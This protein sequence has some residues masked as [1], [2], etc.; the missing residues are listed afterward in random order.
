MEQ[1]LVILRLQEARKRAIFHQ[2]E[3]LPL[4]RD[5]TQ[6]TRSLE[7]LADDVAR[8]EIQVHLQKHVKQDSVMKPGPVLPGYLLNVQQI[9][10]P[11]A[12]LQREMLIEIFVNVLVLSFLSSRLFFLMSL[13][14]RL[15]GCL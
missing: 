12:L 11:A 4:S 14:H 10:Q 1:A 6:C 8:V 7:T 5:E 9:E 13:D 2:T 15:F 3:D